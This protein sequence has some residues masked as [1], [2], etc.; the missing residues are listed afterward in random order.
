MN[1]QK[2]IES[3][4]KLPLEKIISE[5]H[6][7]QKES[8][9]SISKKCG[10]SRQTITNLCTKNGLRIR[11]VKEATEITKNKGDQHWSY[12]LTK[13][14]DKR[15]KK[16]SVRMKKNN[17]S[18][19]KQTRI[20]MSNSIASYFRKLSLPQEIEFKKYLDQYGLKYEYQY[21]IEQYVI[22]FY[23]S[24]LKVCI[25]ID[26]I[27]KWGKERRFKAGI[28]DEFLK[29]LGY[30]IIRVPKLKVSDS[31]YISDL[32]YRNNIIIRS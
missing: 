6:H 32:L 16:H 3:F 27:H 30:K 5:L 26:S 18:R 15:I 7:K 14:S 20:K 22:D 9:N 25:E 24:D 17:P 12:G 23:L 1:S 31:V 10:V 21:P 4:F 2:K 28:K 11:S 19:N 8:I 29:S 13:K